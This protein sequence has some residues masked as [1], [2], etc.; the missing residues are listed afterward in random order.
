MGAVVM[1]MG[2]VVMVATDGRV[3]WTCGAGRQRSCGTGGLGSLGMRALYQY[4]VLVGGR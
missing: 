1:M 3:R 2:I 4:G